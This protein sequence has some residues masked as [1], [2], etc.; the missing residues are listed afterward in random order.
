[1]PG[2][3]FAG[4]GTLQVQSSSRLALATDLN[5]G[6]LNVVFRD[7]PTVTGPFKLSNSPGGIMTF[8]SA[9]TIPGSVE[10]AGTLVIPVTNVTVQI[11]GTLTLAPSAVLNN[12]GTLRVGA[13]QNNGG[14]VIGNA[15]QILGLASQLI[16]ILSLEF[17]TRRN[18]SAELDRQSLNHPAT[19]QWSGPPGAQ[20]EIETSADLFAWIAIETPATELSPG[21][22]QARL[23]SDFT[24]QPRRFL[25]VR[26][27]PR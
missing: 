20:Y 1:M 22:F 10:I 18:Q 7:F 11:N 24:A 25:R 16:Q 3:T 6:T 15:P 17:S 9:I 23:G 27:L 14:T 5:F 8:N 12:A 13:F 2:V 19:L 26:L 21:S 4:P